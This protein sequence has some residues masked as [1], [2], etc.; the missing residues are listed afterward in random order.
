[1]RQVRAPARTDRLPHFATSLLVD[2]AVVLAPRT[3]PLAACSGE[4][5][6]SSHSKRSS[7]RYNGYADACVGGGLRHWRR[8]TAVEARTCDRVA[9]LEEVRRRHP[10]LEECWTSRGLDDGRFP[11]ESLCRKSLQ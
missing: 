2:V 8:E 9:V 11:Q 3:N 10:E 6:F 5:G 7:S 1:V 4:G